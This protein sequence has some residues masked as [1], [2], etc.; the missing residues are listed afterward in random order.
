[1]KSSVSSMHNV[2]CLVVNRPGFISIVH[3]S[4]Q[5]HKAA[6]DEITEPL[7]AA[8][9]QRYPSAQPLRARLSL[10][11]VAALRKWLDDGLIIRQCFRR[12]CGW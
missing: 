4:I 10:K 3:E 12:G 9:L 7:K 5:P 6:H 11:V 8:A 2:L 1:M